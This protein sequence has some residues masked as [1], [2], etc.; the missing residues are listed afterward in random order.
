MRILYRFYEFVT[1]QY[2][3]D[4]YIINPFIKT[5]SQICALNSCDK[6]YSEKLTVNRLMTKNLTVNRQ[7]DLFLTV[8]RQRDA[9]IETLLS[10]HVHDKLMFPLSN[11]P[12]SQIPAF[13]ISYIYLNDSAITE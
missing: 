12:F 4:F 13:S 2:T 7:N 5:Y 11:L 1:T 10:V 9:P 6:R 3:T 8:N